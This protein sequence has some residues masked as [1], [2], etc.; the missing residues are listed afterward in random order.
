MRD[1]NRHAQPGY[2]AIP[3]PISCDASSPIPSQDA[4]QIFVKPPQAL[5]SKELTKRTKTSFLSRKMRHTTRRGTRTSL[6][7][8]RPLAPALP[9]PKSCDASS[10]IPPQDASQ[11]FGKSPQPLESK[12]LTKRTKNS[13]L[14]SKM[15]HAT[16][17]G[18]RTP[19]SP[20]RPLAPALPGPKSCDASSPIPPQDASK[21]FGKSPQPTES[22]ELPKRTKKSP[23]CPTM[24][25]K[26][27]ANPEPGP[28]PPGLPGP[29]DFQ[30]ES[31]YS[32]VRQL[33]FRQPCPPTSNS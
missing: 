11:I 28:P 21:I 23:L 18:T 31:F 25:H 13:P 14:S 7:P 3:D 12:E 30:H 26:T 24:R 8:Q 15:R 1:I 20:K 5:E 27:S 33:S 19:L 22:K 6:S 17:R 16:R 32:L 29:L 10:Q 9:G 2:T 4:S